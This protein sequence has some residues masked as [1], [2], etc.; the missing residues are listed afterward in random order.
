MVDIESIYR[1]FKARQINLP[2]PWLECCINWCLDE[3]LPA[4]YTTKDIQV[5]VF[6]QWLLVD[7]RVL[8]QPS[9]P[10][11]LSQK[12]KFVLDGKYSVQIMHV[13]DISKP[14][15]CQLQKI[16]N[17][18]T[19]NVDSEYEPTK[20][21]LMLKLT[22]GVQEIEAVEYEPIAAL[23]LNLPPGI[24]IG[25]TGPML[26]RRGKIMLKSENVKIIGGEVDDL[27]IQNAP[28]N[29]LAKSLNLPLSKTPIVIE[30]R[31]LDIANENSDVPDA[32]KEFFRYA[33]LIFY[34]KVSQNVFNIQGGP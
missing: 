3:N 25:L 8:E 31:V 21:M 26:I 6:E 7:L 11:N 16:R 24:K 19:K 28:E 12:V 22:D 18:S 33:C 2:L 23:N 32:G 27:L 29:V 9:L 13:I 14:K 10:A 5:K 17:K 15:F 1:L 34:V 20:R 4:N 30:E